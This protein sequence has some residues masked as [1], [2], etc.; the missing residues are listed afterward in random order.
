ML[1]VIGYWLLVVGCWLLVVGC[2]LAKGQFFGQAASRRPHEQR[3]TNNQQPTT[4][5]RAVLRP[6]G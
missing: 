4:A 2:S 5:V 3:T 1:L 6:G